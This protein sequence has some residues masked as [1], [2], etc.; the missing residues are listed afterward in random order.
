MC[1]ASVRAVLIAE[2]DESHS[3]SKGGSG[4][5]SGFGFAFEFPAGAGEAVE[6]GVWG[7]V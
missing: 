4:G 7:C 1:P 5:A 3:G 2:M 6:A